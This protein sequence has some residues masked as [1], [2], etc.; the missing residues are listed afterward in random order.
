MH[1][2]TL[3]QLT[4]EDIF[5]YLQVPEIILL[6]AGNL[7]LP[8]CEKLS[9]G[10]AIPRP[11]IMSHTT[12]RKVVLLYGFHITFNLFYI[13][14]KSLIHLCLRFYYVEVNDPVEIALNRIKILSFL[15]LSSSGIVVPQVK[16]IQFIA[17]YSALK[18]FY[19]GNH[20][21][22]EISFSVNTSFLF[23]VSEIVLNL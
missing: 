7:P 22:M 12:K 3:L 9:Q 21:V 14:L 11:E 23:P 10:V 16:G 8:H 5:G 17:P 18:L 13:S 2:N 20:F 1:L 4:K 15:V 19:P 6:Q